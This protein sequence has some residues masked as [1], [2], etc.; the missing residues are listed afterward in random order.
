MH[1]QVSPRLDRPHVLYLLL[2]FFGMIFV[3]NVV[4]VDAAIS[5]FGGVETP[6]PYK[7]GLAFEQEVAAAG[8]AAGRAALAGERHARARRRGR[9][10]ARRD[11]ARRARRAALRSRPPR[12]VWC[13]PP[14]TQLDRVVAVR[15]VAEGVFHG[16]AAALPGQWDLIVD[17]YRGDGDGCS[18]RATG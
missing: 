7:A 13:I 15:R 8:G 18:V 11:R 4:L 2:G 9:R 1:A 14:T 6:S 17:L 12:H 3:V 10:G 5:T 16:A